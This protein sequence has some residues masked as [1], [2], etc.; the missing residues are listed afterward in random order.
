MGRKNSNA[1]K[2]YPVSLKQLARELELNPKQRVKIGKFI[3][4]LLKEV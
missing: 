1:R 4:K 3:F 2:V